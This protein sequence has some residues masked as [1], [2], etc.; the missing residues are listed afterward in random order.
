MTDTF[1]PKALV[2]Q[3]QRLR[4]AARI[5][6]RQSTAARNDALQ[7]MAD[8]L[9]EHRHQILKANQIDVD[10]ARDAQ[11]EA[12]FV[13][14][15]V[16]DDRRLEAMAQAIEEIVAL[17]DP[18][19]GDDEMWTRP[20]GLQVAR[21]RIP[22]GVIGIIYESRPNVTS[23]AAAL[24]LKSGN[25][26]LLKGGSD[27]FRSNRA[28]AQ[29]LRQGLTQS[30]LPDAAADAI[31]FVNTTDRGA[32]QTMLGLSDSID[33]IIPRGGKGLIRFVHEHSKIPVIKHDEGVC[34]IV[35][36]GTAGAEDIDRIV[37]NAKTQRPGVCNALETL[38]ILDNAVEP[39][40]RRLLKILDEAGV[41]LHLC[42]TSADEA[43]ALGITDFKT[44]DD[45]AYA[46]E[47]LSLELAL[48]V[49][50]D[51]DDAIAH[52][53]RFGSR[54]TESL[55]TNDYRQSRR[56]LDEIDSSVVMINASTRFSDGGQ[57]GLGAEIGISTT[58]LHAYGP[59]GLRELTT[60]KFVILGSGQIRE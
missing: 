22:L 46:A 29:A 52:I 2:D 48:R 47:F 34:H 42:P 15:L 9:R 50:D 45:Q 37:L 49:V 51:L 16:L 17:D 11:M 60:T 44:A 27:A 3:A 40:L 12:A 4:A 18:I 25:G 39:H 33:V 13:D 5:L 1:H 30:A 23:D 28:I 7:K 19:G 31:G 55:L 54:H 26:V 59:M 57:L 14:R 20:N 32:V 53:D 56:F 24:C 43:S 36:D 6:A 10:A 58:R 35:I 21:R 41:T 38:L 8:A